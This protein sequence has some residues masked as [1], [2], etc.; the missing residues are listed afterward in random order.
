MMLLMM[1]MMTSP[2]HTSATYVAVGVIVA[3][4]ALSVATVVVVCNKRS[5]SDCG[6]PGPC[7]P[8]HTIPYTENPA[9]DRNNGNAFEVYEGMQARDM[10]QTLD[11]QAYAD[12]APV[13]GG[14]STDGPELN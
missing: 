8:A 4:I 6:S 1:E 12:V 13:V 11:G 7:S 9:F 3:V 14:T 2:Y 5:G 10:V